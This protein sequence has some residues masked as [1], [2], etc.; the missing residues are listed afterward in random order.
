MANLTFV[1]RPPLDTNFIATFLLTYRSF[2]TT[3]EFISLLEG[4]YNLLPPERL[5]PEQLE[6]W[7]ERKQKLIRLR[8]SVAH[9]A[10]MPID[11][12]PWIQSL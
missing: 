10:A 9:K 1:P 4:R 8:Y 11:S 3:E 7:T 6:L 2:C 12:P 5:T